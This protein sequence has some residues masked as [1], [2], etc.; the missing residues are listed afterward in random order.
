MNS[1]ID[2]LK[3]LGP[4]RLAAMGAVAA[5]IIAFFIFMTSQ[6]ASDEMALLYGDLDA[7]DSGEITAQLDQMGIPY[8][9]GADGTEIH[10]PESDVARIRL[11]MAEQGLP[12]GGSVGYEIFDETSGLGTTN[13]VQNI[14][15]LR[16]LEGELA[17]TIRSIQDVQQARV[18]LVLPRRELF[19]RD[20]QEPSA[21]IVLLMRGSTRL[22]KKRIL[23]VQHL[24]ASAVP[25]LQPN[26]VSIVDQQGTLLARGGEG[27]DLLGGN[28]SPQ[29]MRANYEQRLAR[30]LEQ[31]I[32]RSVGPGNVR[33]EVS[34][35][36]N[37][38]RVT[39][40][41]EIFD[42]DSQIARSEQIVE[43]TE[44]E[45]DTE[46]EDAVTVD[47]NLPNP[48]AQGGQTSS[49]QSQAERTEETIN[50][51]ISK[52][53][54]THVRQAGK[55]DRLSVAVLID[56]R[57][58]T[59]ANG[60][61]VYEERSAEEL[62]QLV[63]LARSAVGYDEERGDQVEV[64]NMRFANPAEELTPAE[65]TTILGLREE[66]LM[67][68][69]ELIVLGIVAVLI[70]LLVVRPLVSRLLDASLAQPAAAG[71]G[72]GGGDPMLSDQSEA[73]PQLAGPTSVPTTQA[74]S[75]IPDFGADDDE[76]EG[77]Q[78]IDLNKVEGRVR[79]SS[80]RK[81]GEIVENHPEEA[82]SII[83]NW[84]YQQQG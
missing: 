50:Y 71:A 1:F 12:N 38:D 49:S 8:Q 33:A 78:L 61:R 32:E 18:H 75:N 40:N 3:S 11:E 66:Q 63:S 16:A 37:F 31:L 6:L 76:E 36:M 15:H 51:E 52:T 67:R 14:N 17:R 26:L 84:L 81:I 74:A 4:T 30:T 69:A 35:E 83:R 39:E 77:E 41:Q 64:I 58:V 65:P 47:N 43:E 59:D 55:V 70:L 60:E 19:S 9:L 45:V 5:G 13:F 79:A 73:Y 80:V 10:V 22:G 42:P 48:Q 21:S 53:V 44:S 54:T 62:Q 27:D 28:L 25:G 56:G 68:A 7:R 2:T 46:G 24:V 34:A 23:G 82:V 29:E 72:A 57:Y 20:R